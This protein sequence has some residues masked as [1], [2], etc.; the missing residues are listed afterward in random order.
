MVY[1]SR[2]IGKSHWAGVILR[3]L[4]KISE[5]NKIKSNLENVEYKA[6]KLPSD[7][8][9]YGDYNNQSAINSKEADLIPPIKIKVL[10]VSEKIEI[11]K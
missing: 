11:K 10:H 8:N 6:I 2:C 1:D 5:S 3:N 4:P 7:E 9:Q